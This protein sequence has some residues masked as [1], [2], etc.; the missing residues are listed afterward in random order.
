MTQSPS[1]THDLGK[2]ASLF[3]D[4][5]EISQQGQPPN[6]FLEASFFSRLFFR[7]PYALMKLGLER[8]I[9]DVDLPENAPTEGS[10]VNLK[11]MD[12]MWSNEQSRVAQI[13]ERRKL[14]NKPPVRPSLHRAI[15]LD[16]LRSVWYVQVSKIHMAN[17]R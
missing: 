16:F 14:T 3:L 6:A 13:N 4:E 1:E 17:F 7:W 11:M 8:P 15:F 9:R 2:H 5:G 10:E 12:R